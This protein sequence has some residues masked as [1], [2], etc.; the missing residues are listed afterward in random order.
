MNSEKCIIREAKDADLRRLA[1]LYRAFLEETLWSAPNV[2]PNP[3]LDVERVVAGH[4][5]GE[6]SS[7]LAA[8][9]DGEIVGFACV[10]FR[11]GSDR[12]LDFWGRVGEFFTH[13]RARLAVLFG[14]HGYL[15]HLF[16]EERARRRGIGSALVLASRDWVR[17]RGGR[18]LEL[19]VLAEND[20]ARKLYQKLA[21]SELLVHYRM[22]F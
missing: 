22:E 21:M 13:R 6:H 10:E 19:N 17:H 11:P 9:L 12:P 18:A 16:V 20:P 2:T 8:E 5:R 3:R 4:L 15:V 7:V 1:A 14:A